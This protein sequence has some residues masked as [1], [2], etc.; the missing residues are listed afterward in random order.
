MVRSLHLT[1]RLYVKR[2]RRIA[3]SNTLGPK[4]AELIIAVRIDGLDEIRRL[5]AA[6]VFHRVMSKFPA[7]TSLNLLWALQGALMEVHWHEVP[8]EI[9]IQLLSEGETL[10]NPEPD[11]S[12]ENG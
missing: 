11:M 9:R 1:Q 10:S 12:D 6:V 3:S 2:I 7:S 4:S 8:E 5:G